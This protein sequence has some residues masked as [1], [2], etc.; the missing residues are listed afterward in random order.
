MLHAVEDEDYEQRLAERIAET[1]STRTL[2][3]Y[4]QESDARP[5][6]SA[7]TW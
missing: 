5:Y 7:V 3:M 2:P 1:R 4:G 6:G